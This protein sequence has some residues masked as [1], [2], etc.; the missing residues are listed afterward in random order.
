M[1][2][3]HV[4]HVLPDLRVG[5]GQTVVLTLL[6]YLDRSRYRVTVCY[7]LPGRDLEGPFREAG[8]TTVFLDHRGGWRSVRTLRRLV[9]LVRQGG[10]DVIHAHSSLDKRYARRAAALSRVPVVYHLHGTRNTGSGSPPVRARIAMAL[11]GALEGRRVVRGFVAVSETVRADHA[12]ILGIPKDRIV[13]VPNVVRVDDF[14]VVPESA[15]TALRAELGLSG[16]HPVLITVARFRRHKGQAL[17]L[18][19]MARIR[20]RWPEAVLLMVGDGPERAPLEAE[21]A[22]AGLGQ[23][24]RFLGNVPEVPPLLSASDVFVFPSRAEGFALAVAEAMAAGRPVVAFRLPAVAEYVE[25]GVTGHLVDQGDPEAL[26][27]GVLRVLDRPDL[28]RG[29]GAR[30]R[31]LV[32]RRFDPRASARVLERVYDEVI[33]RA[34]VGKGRGATEGW[35]A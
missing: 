6:P 7:L 14:P 27:S 20:E 31:E 26:A 4:L 10:I 17:L 8:L 24:I 1:T 25:D 5:G 18:P 34:A 30:G 16:A 13:V 32:A 29:M 33:E 2:V 35:G 15:S 21:V 22:R 3:A 12:A 11:E 23:C 19:M 9:R 28:G